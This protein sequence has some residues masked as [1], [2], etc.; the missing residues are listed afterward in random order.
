[1]KKPARS[2]VCGLATVSM[3]SLGLSL[4]VAVPA[5]AAPSAPSWKD[6][7]A[8]KDDQAAKQR[9]VDALTARMSSLQAT[10]DRT[11]ATVQEAGQR[12]S[13][14]ASQQQEAKDT[15][16]GLTGQ[17]KRAKAAA[18]RSAGQVAA[19][20]V[21]LSRS[22]GG[23]LSTSMLVDS[24]DAKDL[25]YQVGTMTHLSERSATVL[26]KAQSDQ[27]TV[28]ALA[29]QQRQATKA[30]TAATAK[31][32]DALD[33]AND[34]AANAQSALASGQAKQD[35]VLEQLAFIKGTSVATEQ[36]YWSAQ[37]AK[38][39]EIQLAAQAKRDAA[40]PASANGGTDGPG[41]STTDV[42]PAPKPV[43]SN[44]ST[45][46]PSSSAPSG[47]TAAAPKPAAP[48]P[49]A[50]KPAA[51]QPAPQPAA[52]APKPAAPKPAAPKPA[53]PAPAPAP[54]VS[55][56]SK[57]A[58]AIAY[59]RGQLGKAY[60]L[61]GAGPNVWDCSGLVMMAYNSQGITTGG[62]NV[63]WQYNYFGSIGRLVP[64][65]QRQPGDI[66]FY[67]N[68][69][70]ASGGYHDSIYTGNGRMV[71][72]ARPGVGVVERAVWTPSQLLPYVARPSGAL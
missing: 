69:G 19:L 61:G 20:V 64:L 39:A 51:P 63:V 35:E 30:L 12:Y 28:D 33:S 65:S 21:E 32:K 31:T 45:S 9:T 71:E 26:D 23:D 25:L 44:P 55:S 47:G 5:Q 7:Q 11:G 24:R 48:K 37:Q 52:P 15:L 67:S 18:K 62:H 54:V 2:L 72:A 22:G 1:M 41:G 27:R 60:V 34:V 36:A 53:A 56:P 46:N 57:A 38:Q 16:D 49:A 66:L 40:R 50:P 17:A 4:V 8:A 43:T 14:A 68:N 10:V 13:L 29:A 6:V 70:A 3:L 59:A 42:P 58:G